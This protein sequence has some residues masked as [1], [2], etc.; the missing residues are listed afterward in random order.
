MKQTFKRS[1][2]GF[3]LAETLLAM[4]I[5]LMVSG[6]MASGIP[7]AINIYH[8]IVDASN[9]QALISTTMTE[10]RDKLALAQDFENS[11]ATVITYT[12]DNGR[13]HELSFDENVG[14]YINDITGDGQDDSRLLVSDPA[15]SKNLYVSFDSI[16][17]E[18]GVVAV[19]N[20]KV[21]RKNSTVEYVEIDEYMIKV[22]NRQQDD[23]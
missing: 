7:T 15:A 18:E 1:K 12:G 3:T 5:L 20:L 16:K 22:L 14:I 11:S 13:K 9:A 4:L 6:L 23:E 17:Y 8:K 21:K 10:L 19:K 2:Q